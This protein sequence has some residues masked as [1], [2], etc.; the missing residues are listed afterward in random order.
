[1]KNKIGITAAALMV[2]LSLTACSN[3]QSQNSSSNTNKT[4]TTQVQ[5]KKGKANKPSSQAPKES[6]MDQLNAQLKKELPSMSLPKDSG[7]NKGADKLNVH[8]TKSKNHNTVYYSVG[9][10]S[11][12]FNAKKARS[13]KPYAVLTETTNVSQ[14]KASELINYMPAQSGLPTK[15]LDRN[16]KATVEG[17]AGQQYLQWNKNNYS[18]VIQASKVLKQ[19]AV[20]KGKEVL[21]LYKKYQLPKT[22]SKG[23]LHVKVGDSQGSLNTIITWQKG[24]NIYQLKAH[25]TKTALKMLASL[26]N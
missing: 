4:S 12:S 23:S 18:F 16:T 17:A 19:D 5:K 8:Y 22:S 2:A 26:D 3:N 10:Q 13:E 1:M 15:K 9:K 11:L 7:L 6:R 14:S 25:D 24:N 21:A 20:S